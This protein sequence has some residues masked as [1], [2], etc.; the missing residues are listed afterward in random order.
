MLGPPKARNLD[1]PVLISLE[2]SVPKDH[3][4]RPL[5]RTL[6]LA[7]VRDLAATCYASGGR[8]SIDPV[9][10]F[11]LHLIMFFEG[12]RS[13]RKLIEI[14]SLNLAHRWYL[15]YN[16]D[17]PLP[18]HSSLRVIRTR[19]GLPVF[20][21]FFEVIVEQCVQ[22]GLVWGKELIF[23]ATKV[24]ANAA[25]DSLTPVLRLVVDDHLAA[26]AAADVPEEAS[27]WDLLEEC[28]LDPDRPPTSYY[29][30]KS[31]GRKSTTDP[32]A[33]LMKPR[34]ERACLGYHDHCVVDG[35]KARIILH[36]LVTPADVMENQPMLD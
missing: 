34:G 29:E 10:F 8:P 33:A 20:R 31:D 19:L 17:E 32:D 1:R 35:G 3:F 6:D 7:F 9:V 4:Y 11:K 15:G 28:R 22:A 23:D 21:R 25:M 18:D 14:A 36:A 13:E 16:L 24:R 30:R 5:E 12:L 27:R 26:L 2:A